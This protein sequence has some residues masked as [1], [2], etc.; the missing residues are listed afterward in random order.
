MNGKKIAITG[1][2]LCLPIGLEYNDCLEF[3][4]SGRNDSPL[5]GNQNAGLIDKEVLARKI[6]PKSAFQVDHVTRMVLNVVSQCIN[7]GRIEVAKDPAAVGILSGSL[8]GSFQTN[9]QSIIDLTVKG[10]K[11]I[12]PEMFPLTSHNYPISLAAIEFGLKGPITSFIKSTNAGLQALSY[13]VQLLRSGLAKQMIVVAYEE[14]NKINMAVLQEKTKLSSR[15]SDSKPWSLDSGGSFLA[16]G[17]GGLVIED[18]ESAKERGAQILGEV[19]HCGNYFIPGFEK[20]QT[21][22]QKN[23]QKFRETYADLDGNQTAYF[24]NVNGNPEDDAMEKKMA[25]ELSLKNVYAVKPLIGN[26]LGGSGMIE[27]VIALEFLRSVAI[28]GIIPKENP[29]GTCDPELLQYAMVSNFDFLGNH[30]LC[31]IGK[32]VS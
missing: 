8:F 27:S 9:C 28:R 14:I 13:G 23:L 22:L 12:D 2:G 32:S 20:R 21:A 30:A 11:F 15:K 24:L 7:S 1:R 29:S 18:Y 5:C 19:I 10:P 3:M 31:F 6:S 17:C 26:Y 25:E 4:L 16:E